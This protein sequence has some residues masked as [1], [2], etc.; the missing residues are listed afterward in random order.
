[1]I[2]LYELV[3]E[4]IKVSQ[5]LGWILC[6][7]FCFRLSCHKANI[8]ERNMHAYSLDNA[9]I[10]LA[11]LYGRYCVTASG[12]RV[13]CSIMR[14]WFKLSGLKYSDR[15]RVDPSYKTRIQDLWTLAHVAP[16]A[17]VSLPRQYMCDSLPSG[18]KWYIY[19]FKNS[20]APYWHVLPSG[21]PPEWC[22]PS[23]RVLSLIRAQNEWRVIS[24]FIHWM[25]SDHTTTRENLHIFCFQCSVQAWSSEGSCHTSAHTQRSCIFWSNQ[26]LLT[27]TV[28]YSET[29]VFNVAECINLVPTLWL[30]L[31][32]PGSL[33]LLNV[34][35][36]FRVGVNQVD[37]DRDVWVRGR[38]RD[39]FRPVL[40]LTP[41]IH[42]CLSFFRSPLAHSHASSLNLESYITRVR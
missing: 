4:K 26:Y 20:E 35:H 29:H 24:R 14:V 1:M 2:S 3:W 23:K 40:A 8:Q 13:F 6:C 16:D 30:A 27:Y 37:R 5:L 19:V 21:F 33:K 31:V 39:Q 38:Q 41:S 18:E 10:P 9:W 34:A 32:K 7:L 36:S 12:V 15:L 17:A 42:P 25:V 28:G 11:S 22:S